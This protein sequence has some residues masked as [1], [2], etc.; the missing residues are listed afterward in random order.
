MIT[1]AD[2]AISLLKIHVSILFISTPPPPP[3]PSSSLE[4]EEEEEEE[5]NQQTHQFTLLG[6]SSRPLTVTI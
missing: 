2:L 4:E 1:P 3:S 5:V 6:A